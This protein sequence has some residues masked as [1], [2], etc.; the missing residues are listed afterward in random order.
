VASLAGDLFKVSERGRVYGYILTGEL[1]GSGVGIFAGGQLGALTWRLSFA[2]LAIPGI[3]LAV[4][5]WRLLPEPARGGQS[6]LAEGAQVI[7]SAGDVAAG[8][9]PEGTA[10]GEDEEKAS[11][12]VVEE[13]VEGQH[14][15]PRAHLVLHRDPAPR[16]LWW[17]V[18]YV[19]SIPTNAMLIVASALGYFYFQGIETFGVEFLRARF[20]LGQGTASSL[21]IVI[22][23]GALAGVL[24]TGRLADRLIS[25]GR[26]P[27]RVIV[28]GVSF[29]AAVVFLVPGLFVTSTAAAIALFFAGAAGLGG[30]NPPLDAARLDIMHSRLWGRAEAVRTFFR[31]SLEAVSPLLFGYVSTRFGSRTSG[32]GH[33]A[34]PVTYGAPALDHT[35]LLMLVTLVAAGLVMIATR[36]TYPRDVATAMASEEA[37]SRE[38]SP[39]RPAG[40]GPLPEP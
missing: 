11:A 39:G 3:A 29:L 9:V 17:A 19:L 32:L 28:T 13:E 14:I 33:P 24:I 25:S 6:R 22:G 7:P 26:V 18:R 34:G 15:P 21:L 4:A 31:S 37:V 35:F 5:L 1:A 12:G 27:G 20:G 38:P 8:H 30:A 23:I 36:R 2:W 10:A 40:S 16:N